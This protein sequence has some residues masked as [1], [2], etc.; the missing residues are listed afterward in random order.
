MRYNEAKEIYQAYTLQELLDIL[1]EEDG[2]EKDFT[3]NAREYFLEHRIAQQNA[4]ITNLRNEL[5]SWQNMWAS[6]M[7][8]LHDD[9][10]CQIYADYKALEQRVVPQIEE[11]R[12]QKQSLKRQFKSGQLAPRSYQDALKTVRAQIYQLE[13]QLR[14]FGYKANERLRGCGVISIQ[15]ICAYVENKDKA[16]SDTTNNY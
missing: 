16:E 14:V 4:H 10:V 12:S 7:M 5:S 3:S 8:R 13:E 1:H 15:D 11:L 2:G 9:E 6:A